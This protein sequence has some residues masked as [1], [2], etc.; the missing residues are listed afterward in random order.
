MEHIYAKGELGATCRQ[1]RQGYPK[2]TMP[3]KPGRGVGILEVE[4]V[5]SGE[6]VSW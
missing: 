1:A 6:G 5:L 2:Y 3:P 4:H